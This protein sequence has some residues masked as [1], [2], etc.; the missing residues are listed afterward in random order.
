[1][2]NKNNDAHDE[3]R[4]YGNITILKGLRHDKIRVTQNRGSGPDV[5]VL[6]AGRH[7]CI[8]ICSLETQLQL[9]PSG[10][11]NLNLYSKFWFT[12]IFRLTRIIEERYC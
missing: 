7:V 5:R 4:W 2:D 3:R 11:F 8:S 9:W 12:N 1:M 6:H 10:I